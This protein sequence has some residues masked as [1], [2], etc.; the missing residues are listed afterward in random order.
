[1]LTSPAVRVPFRRLIERLWPQL[2]V[3][4]SAEITGDMEIESLGVIG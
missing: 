3:V 1:V 2:R 4:S